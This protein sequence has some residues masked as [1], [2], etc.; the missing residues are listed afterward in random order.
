[1]VF[2]S[3]WYVALFLG[4]AAVPMLARGSEPPTGPARVMVLGVFHFANPGRDMVKAPVADVMT[5]ANQAYLAGLATRLASFR[6][7]D[8]LVECVPSAQPRHDAAYGAYRDGRAELG[9]DETQ[10]IGY[11]VAREVGIDAVTCFDEGDVHWQGGPLLEHIAVREPGLKAEMDATFATLS[12]RE[13]REQAS[14]ELPDLLR[15]SNDPARDRESKGLYILTNG[16]GAGDGFIGA[17]ASA[18]WW[19]RNFR[20]Y[21]NVQAA[22]APGRRVLVIAGAGHTA[23]LKDLLAIDGQRQAE[24][25]LPYLVPASAGNGAD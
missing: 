2:R 1:M 22:A 23:I 8:V 3:S 13:A 12:A 15:L 21:A 6:P 11:R 10:Q 9:V 4:I 19:H 16:V 20:M 5:A 25:V 17:D 7:T 14:L 24:D 18:S